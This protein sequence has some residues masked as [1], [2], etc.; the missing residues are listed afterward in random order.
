MGKVWLI[1]WLTFASQRTIAAIQ[2]FT[3]LEKAAWAK[4]KKAAKERENYSIILSCHRWQGI[5][6]ENP[7]SNDGLPK[8]FLLPKSCN[9][10]SL[11]Q[12]KNTFQQN[13]NWQSFTQ[14]IFKFMRCYFY[15][16]LDCQFSSAF[17]YTR[18]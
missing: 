9:F 1:L 13:I 3:K 15:I 4:K 2:W 12:K 5:M 11:M 14:I 6:W 10:G 17:R 16:S 8:K 7:P 18:S